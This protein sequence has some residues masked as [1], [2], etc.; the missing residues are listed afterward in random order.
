MH[1]K[2]VLVVDDDPSFCEFQREVL[3]SEGF[4]VR[5]ASSGAEALEMLAGGAFD[6]LILDVRM[7]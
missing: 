1:D 4:Q 7:P 6:L 5:A 2:A 3:T